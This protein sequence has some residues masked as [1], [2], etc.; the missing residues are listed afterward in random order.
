MPNSIPLAAIACSFGVALILIPVLRAAASRLKR[1][2]DAIPPVGGVAFVISGAVAWAALIEAPPDKSLVFG[3]FGVCAVGVFDDLA[4]RS[5]R[6]K[7][8]LLL[9]VL[10]FFVWTGP[11]TGFIQQPILEWAVHAFWLLWMCNAF[12]VLD[13]VDGLSAGV[14]V[15]SLVALVAITSSAGLL[16]LVSICALLSASL[17][18]YLIYN[19]HP[20]RVYMGDAGSLL[21]G[22]VLGESA[23]QLRPEIGGSAGIVSV[24]LLVAVPFFEA[25]FLILIR[26]AKVTMPSVSTED[27]PPQRLIAAGLSVR[28]A[29]LM[30]YLLTF[31][32]A[33]AGLTVGYMGGNAWVAIAVGGAGLLLVTG[34]RLGRVDVNRDGQDGRPG[35][36]FSK[37]WLV[38][39]IVHRRMADVADLACGTLV[40]LGCGTR[41]YAGLFNEFVDR[42]VAIDADHLR[43]AD[44]G[45]DLVSDSSV[46]SLA[47]QSVDT[48]LSNQVLEHLKEPADAVKEMARVLRPGGVAII[49]APHI[50]G[51][52]EEPN[53]FYRFTSFG[54][55]H[56]AESSGLRVQTVEAMAGYWVTTGARFCY[57]LERFDRGPFHPL[58]GC[59]NYFVQMGAFVLDHFHRV[60]GDAWNHLMIAVKPDTQ[61]A[62]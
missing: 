37:N 56:L 42:Y 3:V 20:A 49:T 29:V 44:G 16:D 57:Y 23:W 43:Y 4:A 58:I 10:G 39:R 25:V 21:I 40:D 22:F 35:S 62:T 28:S 52:H 6:G 38:N 27:H 59:L 11:L 33:G 36:V 50:W 14:G 53:D 13:A 17:I 31:S 45:L 46:L 24:L 15:I 61:S 48:V 1:Y 30:M 18:P 55:R 2:Q 26:L 34:V 41:P 47:D 5:A 9:A 19:F 54:L 7:T 12:N 32:L 8:M 51:V 60:E